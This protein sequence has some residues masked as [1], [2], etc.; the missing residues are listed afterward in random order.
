MLV[1]PTTTTTAFE[2]G[3]KIDDTLAMYMSDIL[4]V[5]VNLAG[6]PSL[7][8]PCGFS[9]DMPVGMQIISK[10]FD[11]QMMYRVAYAFEKETDFHKKKPAFKGGE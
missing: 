1:A 2:I 3:G 5:P 4:T 9:N 11:E 8:I 6:V 10:H 7:S